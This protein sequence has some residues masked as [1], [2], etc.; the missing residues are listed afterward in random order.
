[1]PYTSKLHLCIWSYQ[2][3]SGLLVWITKLYKHIKTYPPNETP[4]A[5]RGTPGFKDFTCLTT[6]DKSSKFAALYVRGV[7]NKQLSSVTNSTKIHSN[8]WQQTDWLT[9]WTNSIMKTSFLK[10]YMLFKEIIIIISKKL[11]S[12][13]SQTLKRLWCTREYPKFLDW[14]DNKI[15]AYNK[16]SRINPK[17]YSSKT[18]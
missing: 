7:W 10:R 14:V 9:D 6:S 11:Y 18:H 3:T 2:D 8:H 4:A 15:Y 13:T 12:H 5:A 17:D 16:H 1:V